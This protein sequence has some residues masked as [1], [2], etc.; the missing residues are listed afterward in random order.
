[1]Q[2]RRALLRAKGN[3]N[4]EDG[5]G[6]ESLSDTALIDTMRCIRSSST[7]RGWSRHPAFARAVLHTPMHENGAIR[8]ADGER[9]ACTAGNWVG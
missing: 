1:V 6:D 3:C 5:N 2:H 9:L 7:G 8:K 4:T